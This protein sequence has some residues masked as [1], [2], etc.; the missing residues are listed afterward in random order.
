M[1]NLENRI[2]TRK[3]TNLDL[4]KKFIDIIGE[5]KNN[6]ANVNELEDNI[7]QLIREEKEGNKGLYHLKKTLLRQKAMNKR[8]ILWSIFFLIFIITL[9]FPPIMMIYSMY[10]RWNVGMF[11]GI[12]LANILWG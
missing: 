1:T 12:I 2:I 4:E 6:G 11:C 10:Y 7:E 9:L 3:M 8:K 5:L